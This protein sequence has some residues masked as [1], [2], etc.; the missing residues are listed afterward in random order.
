MAFARP[1]P[2]G[3]L[4]RPDSLPDR[5]RPAGE[6]TAAL[7][8]DHIV[9]LVMENHSFDCYFGMLPRLGQPLADGFEFDAAGAPANRNPYR[10]GYVV[11]FRATTECQASVTQSWNATHRQ[12][13]GGRMDGFAASAPQSMVYWTDADLP[14]YY[15]LAKEF[16]LANRWFGSAPCQT[17]PNRRFM[18]AGT[19]FGL[20]S[21]DTQAILT[22]PPPPNGTLFDRLNAHGIGWKNYFVDLPGTGVIPSILDTH[23][24]GAAPIAQFFGDCAAGTLPPVSF[25]DPEFGLAG[26][27]GGP[28]AA[29]LP[30]SIKALGTTINAQGGD[31]ENPQD[32]QIGENF[33]AK[34]VNAVL[35]SPAWPR[36]LFVWT[37]DEHGGYYD[38]VPPPRA[39]K[40]DSIPPR[41]S[42]TDEPGGYDI[43]GPRVPAV[44]VSPYS[45]PKS[46]SS[47]VCD[48]TSVMATIEAKWN[49][50]ACTYRDANANTL[51]GFLGRSPK[52]LEP[53][54]LAAPSDPGPGEQNCSDAD[55]PLPVQ[56]RWQA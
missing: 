21:T 37:Y 14:F 39:V 54:T 43:Y 6:P 5:T 16:T 45:R 3:W 35:A 32:I 50:P 51:A 30:D 48:H 17:Y 15:S 25:V 34:V 55:P 46:V 13:N 7:P 10:S 38:H 56:H 26:E 4:R 2:R 23:P 19:A 42:P 44:V 22:D 52:L 36:T 18:L 29:A 11:P 53:P 41:T 20:I 40:P 1:G 31:E 28:L 27:I 33:G 49:L 12:I 24:Q 47:L 8:F 9:V